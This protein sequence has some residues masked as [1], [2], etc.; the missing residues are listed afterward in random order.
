MNIQWFGK[1]VKEID[2][3]EVG[4]IYSIKDYF[5]NSTNDEIKQKF[6]DKVVKNQKNDN[7]YAVF[8][9]SNANEALNKAKS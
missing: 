8:M 5:K 2:A 4:N 3:T 7:N 6:G 9:S 1:A